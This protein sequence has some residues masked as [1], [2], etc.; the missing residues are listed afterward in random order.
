MQEEQYQ[1][2]E[3]VIRAAYKARGKSLRDFIPREEIERV[4]TEI[5]RYGTRRR[6]LLGDLVERY[7]FGLKNNGRAEADFNIANVE[8]KTTPLKR[9]LAK[10]LVSKE[11]LVF[12]MINYDSVIEE[13]WE[14]SSFLKKNRSLLI[15]FYLWLKEAD[16]LDYEFKF[17]HFLDLLNNLSQEDILQ[18]QKDWEFIV[19]KIRRGEAHLLSEGDTFYLGACTKAANNKVVRDQPRSR[20]PA[21]PRAFSLKQSYLNYLIQ[22]RLLGV[23]T[24]EASLYKTASKNKTVAQVVREKFAP[25]IGK[26]DTEICA[27]LGWQPKRKSKNHNRLLVNRILTGTGTNKVE[28][29]DKA[30]VTLR[31]PTLEASGSLKESISFPAFYFKDLVTQVWYD[32]K[33]EQMSDFHLQLEEKK[34]LFVVFQKQKDSKE[35]VLRKTMFWNFPAEDMEKAREVWEETVHLLNE[36][37][38]IK[39]IQTQKDGT[40]RLLTHFPGSSYNG[41]IHVRPHGL[42]SKDVSELPMRDQETGRTTHTKQAFWLNA[43][44]VQQAIESAVDQY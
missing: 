35:I 14:T 36:G 23:S 26:T 16:L 30:N 19:G 1:T 38:V 6:G 12:S 39:E 5:K 24:H 29:L 41:V 25:Y 37:K 4:E 18:I 11:R 7:I 21:K 28:E 17:I 40:K 22:T 20:I 8:L 32:E 2:V 13:V 33:E 43:S 34:F 42:N 9:H 27:M 31:V 10:R 44:Y 3:D 15:M